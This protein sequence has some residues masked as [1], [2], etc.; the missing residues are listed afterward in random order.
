MKKLEIKK[1]FQTRKVKYGGYAA[2]TTVVVIAILLVVNLFAGELNWKVD[3]TKNQIFS[4]SSQ[5]TQVLAGLKQNVDIYIFGE[6][7]KEDPMLKAII[8]KYPL[9]SKMISLQYKDPVKNPQFAK[10]YSQNGVDVTEG[11]IVVSSGQKFRLIDPNDL[12]NYT[13]DQSGNQIPD[14][15][16]VENKVTGAIIY[17]TSAETPVIYTLAGHEEMTLPSSVINQIESQNYTVKSL[18]LAVKDAQLTAGSTLIVASPQRDLNTDETNT[19]KNFLANGGRA[20]FLMDLQNEDLPN[21]QSILNTYGVGIEK[22]VVVEG[23]PAY[24]ASQNP[25]FL[26]PEMGDQDIVSPLKSNNLPVI[27]PG[28][29]TIQEL[30]LKKS[31]TTIEPLLT[32]SSNSWAKTNM[33]FTDLNKEAS[34]IS[35]PI[36][37]AVAITDTS[38]SSGNDTKLVVVSNG[39]FLSSNYAGL[40]GNTDFITNSINWLQDKKDLISITPKSISQASLTLTSL[41]SLLYSGMVVIVIPVIIAVWGISVLLRRKRQ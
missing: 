27:I 3:L 12:V 23:D 36:N 32:T 38:S 8:E 40:Y 33:N 5:S 35:G 4:L 17:V 34:D 10:Q 31:T 13:Y 29:Q 28:A 1:S 22:S 15:L 7:G 37:I 25:L 24:T 30:K 11:S 19:I 20:V 14:S 18:D 26:V 6:A 2:L 41:Q 16:G 21:F 9:A 39:L